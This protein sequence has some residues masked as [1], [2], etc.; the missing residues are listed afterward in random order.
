MKYE[1][2]GSLVACYGSRM[3]RADSTFAKSGNA[4]APWLVGAFVVAIGATAVLGW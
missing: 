2:G 3:T 4:A 1:L